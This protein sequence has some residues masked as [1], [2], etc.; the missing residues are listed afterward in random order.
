[1]TNDIKKIFFDYYNENEKYFDLSEKAHLKGGLFPIHQEILDKCKKKN[2]LIVDLGCGTGLDISKMVSNNNFCLGLDISQLAI[3]KAKS[4]KIKNTDFKRS[5]LE[6]LPLD[7]NSVDIVT[8]FFVFEHLLNPEKVLLEADR[9]LKENGEV[10]ILCPNFSSPFRGA[11]VYGWYSI[12]KILKK[13][14]LSLRRMFNVWVLRKKDFKVKMIDESLIDLSK[15][16][17][18][19]DSTNEPSIFEFVNYFKRKNYQ[20]NFK[21]WLSPPKT[22]TE[23]IF[24]Y[25]KS[26]PIVKYWGPVC[27]LYAKKR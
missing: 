12:D 10:F 13:M 11:P 1:M 16:G 2:G 24:S 5:N 27:Y 6:N 7:D 20:I 23:K 19:W 21:T 4:K 3:N 9:I 17:E 22:K 8:S 14:L 18:D 26:F 25:F 15:N